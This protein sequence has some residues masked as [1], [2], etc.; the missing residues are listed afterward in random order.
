MPPGQVGLAGW[1]RE[2][3]G[4][5]VWSGL[6]GAWAIGVGPLTL[7]DIFLCLAL[8]VVVPMA[9]PLLLADARERWPALLT[10]EPAA[11]GAGVLALLIEP[12]LIAAVL[13][14]PWL[15]VC[16][17]IALGGVIRWSVNRSFAPVDIAR[18][19]A[20]VFLLV[21]GTWFVISR[22][23]WQP[24][25]LSSDIVELTAVHFHYAGMASSLLSALTLV[26]LE[27]APGHG[28]RAGRMAAAA[29]VVGPPI[30]AAGFTFSPVLQVTGAVLL[31]AGLVT[32]AWL[33]LVRV[34]P[35]L[36]A[37]PWRPLLAGSACAVVA[38]MFLAVDW[39][40]GQHVDIPSLSIP[41]MAAIHGS[42]NALGFTFCGILGWR[43]LE[44]RAATSGQSHNAR[45]VVEL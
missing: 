9:L 15:L 17:T 31:T 45:P 34:L 27:E 38:P 3:A 30:V 28:V 16:A 24:L 10:L 13:A 19:A 20:K 18:L 22:A 42:L 29:V 33:I 25:G 36:P 4:A 35:T 41:R 8:L 26:T 2:I 21:G 37:G 23:G 40:L 44:A 39:A 32:L 7:I 43:L 5:A 6:G 12:G 11:A 14:G 1:R